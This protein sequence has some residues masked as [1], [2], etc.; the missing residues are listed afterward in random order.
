MNYSDRQG[1]WV[2]LCLLMIA[3]CTPCRQVRIDSVPPG[4]RVSVRR[5][6]PGMWPEPRLAWEQI[7]ITPLS[8]DS[9]ALQDEL[10]AR[11]N[12]SELPAYYRHGTEAIFFDFEQNEVREIPSPTD[13]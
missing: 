12:G 9:C 2:V 10:K 7:G 3:G 13:D 1:V 8:V 5:E 4:A 6:M 11:W